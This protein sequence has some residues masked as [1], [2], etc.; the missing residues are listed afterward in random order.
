MVPEAA[1]V[2]AAVPVATLTRFPAVAKAL[3]M[4]IRFVDGAPIVSALLEPK[5]GVKNWPSAKAAAAVVSSLMVINVLL[6]RFPQAPRAATR[7]LA[8]LLTVPPSPGL[9]PEATI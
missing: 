9:P 8:V 5:V 2:G 1:V 6:L 4:P 3:V 7:T